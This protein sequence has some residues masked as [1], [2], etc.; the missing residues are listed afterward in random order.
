MTDIIF[1]K[2][3]VI[4]AIE[5][6]VDIEKIY[7]LNTLRGETEVYFR[8]VCKDKNIPLSKVPEIKLKE[9]SRNKVH[10]GLVALISPVTYHNLDDVI[11]RVFEKGKVPLIIIADGVTD[12]RN[13]GA[14]ARSAYFFGAD[15]LVLSGGMGGRIN[16]DAVKT[17]A[18]A[19]LKIPVCRNTS[20]FNLISDLQSAGISVIATGLK[21]EKIIS[22]ADLT[23]PVAII[24]GSEDKGLNPKVN[25]VVDEVVKIPAGTEFDSLNVS[26]AGGIILYETYRQRLSV[27]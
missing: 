5:S 12:V 17:S 25:E 10:Q 23:G 16:D 3:P 20:L 18:G 14:L 13:L 21:T 24:L 19:L 11:V 1:G 8:R 7:M 9:L 15:A 22:E 6:G 4:E 2:N 26:V 27:G